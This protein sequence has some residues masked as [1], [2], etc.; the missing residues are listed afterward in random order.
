MKL[1][2][3]L[4]LWLTGF[5]YVTTKA[6]S[7]IQN[8]VLVYFTTGVQRNTPPYQ[9][10]VTISSLNINQL[11]SNYNLSAVNV[12]PA[13]PDFNEADTFNIEIGEASKQ[14]NYAKV[15]TI[16]LPD[17][18]AKTSLINALSAMP[19]VLY[20]EA[21]AEAITNLIPGDGRFGQQWNMRNTVLPGADIHAEAAWDIYTGN[22]NAI[23]AVIDG[24]V[25]VNHNDLSAKIL[26]GDNTFS[27]ETNQF[28][29]QFSHGS[30]V[31]G[32]AAAVTNNTNNNGVAGVDWQ[33]KIHSK[34][35]INNGLG[36]AGIAKAIR[37]AVAFSP[38][39]W[40][41]NHSWALN[42][43]RDAQGF[44]IP[45]LYS[46][47]VR[48]AFS[49]GYKNNRV[50]CVAMGNH[51][52]WNNG[53]YANIVGYPVGFNSGIIAV[54]ATDIFDGI[55]DFSANGPHIDVSAPGVNI[56]S[57]N[58][59][60]GYINLSGT[61]M[62]TPHVAGLASL[63]KGFN[64]NLANDDIEQIIRLSA[65]DKGAMGFDN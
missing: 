62:A 4:A 7:S 57:T 17:T 29:E 23:I 30:H 22:A 49:T 2:I 45:G 19:E 9:N 64:T 33:A 54:G 13:F 8:Q 41:L 61:S 11:L 21:D 26:G 50:Q 14:M 24:G 34:H 16:L 47:T 43:G 6:Q 25:D 46:V 35:V 31:A 51:Q 28:G 53:I 20:A 27:I 12:T 65:D 52:I 1:K 39:V 60:N 40:T 55:A 44:P 42:K 38:N 5:I 32:I 15:F 58:F 37:D 63:L 18:T 48:S 10:S 59:N 3:I 56:P 36:E